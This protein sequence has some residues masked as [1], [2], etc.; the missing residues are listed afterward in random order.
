MKILITAVPLTGH[1]NPLLDIGRIFIA[2]GHEVVCLSSSVLRDR[3]EAMGASFRPFP[4][5]AD[6]DLRD[7][8]KAFPELKTIPPG[9]R[10][11]RFYIERMFIDPIPAQHE[12]LTQVLQDFPADV[13]IAD[14]LF[15]GAL[16]MLL[17]P[18][19]DRP[20]IVFCGTTPL[21]WHR[22]DGGPH[23]IGLPPATSDAQRHEYALLA[24]AHDESV[25]G[26][27]GRYLNDCLA[28]MGVRPLSSPI[29]DA[30]EELPDAFLQLTVSSFEFPRWDLPASVHFVGAR[31]IV[32]NQ[33]PVPSWGPDVAGSR[34]VVLV[35]QGTLSNHNFN[36]LVTPALAAF[37][38]DAEVLVVVTTGGRSD[39]DI[40]GPIPANARVASYLPFEWILPRT[41]VFVTNGGYGSVNQALSFGVPLVTAGLSEDKADV[42]AH[43]AWSGAGIDLKTNDPTPQALREAVRAVLDRPTYRS[44][45]AALAKE[46][47]SIDTRSEI[48]KI[49]GEVAHA[50]IAIAKRDMDRHA[51]HRSNLWKSLQHG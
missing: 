26:P 14:S 45:A 28:D 23:F 51:V 33:A 34:K 37:A 31:P 3:I 46:F 16:P 1:L 49:I 40:P 19:S 15:H 47:N 2:E 22:E 50:P 29:Y 30:I 32:P 4:G 13:I 18:R 41:D 12:G 43:V 36:Q 5:K 21:F 10:M 25:F 24:K 8:T 39:K 27:T 44:R 48:L 42:N 11:S 17:G 7:I 9:P 6:L 35:T 20:A 38:N